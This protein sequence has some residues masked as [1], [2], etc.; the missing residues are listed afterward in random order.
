MLKTAIGSAVEVWRRQSIL[1][2]ALVFTLFLAILHG[3][4]QWPFQYVGGTIALVALLYRP[5]RV[6]WVTWLSLAV[7]GTVVLVYNWHPVDNHKFLLA[8]WL[9][10]L[11]LATLV[12]REEDAE[13]I[14]RFN[15][16]FFLAFVFLMASAQKLAS[17]SYVDGSFFE[18]TV[19]TDSRFEGFMKLFGFEADIF[20]K[21]NYLHD[22]VRSRLHTVENGTVILPTNPGI[23]LAG[24]LITWWDVL[25]Q[26]AIGAMV[27]ATNRK[28]EITGHIL[29]LVFIYTT[30]FAAP[31][32]GFGWTLSI[33]ALM[34]V[35]GRYPRLSLWYL[36]SFPV[37]ELYRVPWQQ[38]VPLF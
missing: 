12:Q 4:R 14:L 25:V 6:N 26:I 24:T 23:A 20:S 31:V 5:I 21:S 15:A 18:L 7:I 1:E 37:L 13:S 22:L 9:W 29:L 10:V 27:A 17:S 8:Y 2:I 16:R 38:Y 19:L 32:I 28:I 36:A 33:L 34:L 30:Y 35:H 3:F 11:F